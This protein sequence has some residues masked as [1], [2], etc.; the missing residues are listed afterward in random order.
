MTLR[1]AQRDALDGRRDV[2]TRERSQEGVQDQTA[3]H[4]VVRQMADTRSSLSGLYLD[5]GAYFHKKYAY[6][7]DRLPMPTRTPRF[8]SNP[9]AEP[10]TVGGT[11][12]HS[13]CR[14][15]R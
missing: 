13:H 3:Q 11:L 10:I 15:S 14:A 5:F 9:H 7:W 2:P 6:G 4:N 8:S 1:V 12:S